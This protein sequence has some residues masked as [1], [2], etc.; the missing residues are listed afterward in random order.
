MTDQAMPAKVRLTDGL[1]PTLVRKLIG[2]A[3]RIRTRETLFRD[4]E[5]VGEAAYALKE[6]IEQVDSLRDV[7]RRAANIMAGGEG[8]QDQGEAWDRAQRL[9]NAAVAEFGPNVE[10]TGC[11][12]SGSAACWGARNT[13]CVTCHDA[14]YCSRCG[15]VRQKENSD[16]S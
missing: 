11:T 6:T 9:L 7:I 10:L 4:D 12:Q 14:L 5:I 2:V 3:V 8:V 15:A 16:A 1:G 13:A